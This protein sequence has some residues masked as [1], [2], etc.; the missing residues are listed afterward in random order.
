MIILTENNRK[1]QQK[2]TFLLLVL[3]FHIQHA[4]IKRKVRTVGS[5]RCWNADRS[6]SLS[7]PNQPPLDRVYDGINVQHMNIAAKAG[8]WTETACVEV[9]A[10][11]ERRCVVRAHNTGRDEDAARWVFHHF[12]IHLNK[13]SH[14]LMH[15]THTWI[16]AILWSCPADVHVNSVDDKILYILI[17]V[18]KVT[19]VTHRTAG[20]HSSAVVFAHYI[21]RNTFPRRR[22]MYNGLLLDTYNACPILKKD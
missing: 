11:C 17:N 1:I 19:A 2:K 3:F 8:S 15:V 22:T 7:R 16:V 6:P 10:K 12:P 21:A 4:N 20:W 18:E 13:N 9:L 5:P 14:G